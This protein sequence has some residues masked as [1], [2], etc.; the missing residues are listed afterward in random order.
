[1]KGS[2]VWL[3]IKAWKPK[4]SAD[5][6]YHRRVYLSPLPRESSTQSDTFY[7]ISGKNLNLFILVNALHSR[8]YNQYFINLI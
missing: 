3:F 6:F 1:M 2:T 7:K 8:N 4:R 5:S